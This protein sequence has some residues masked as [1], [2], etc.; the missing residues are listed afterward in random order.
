MKPMRLSF[1][2]ILAMSM[3][4]GLTS[5]SSNEDNPVYVPTPADIAGTWW[6][7]HNECETLPA[8]FT[9]MDDIAYTKV[10]RTLS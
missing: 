1:L 8:S 10:G 7:T 4:L 9:G 5:C 3:V 2:L 6:E